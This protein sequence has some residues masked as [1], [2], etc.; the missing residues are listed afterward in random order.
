M[1]SLTSIIDRKH[2]CELSFVI[3]YT[4]HVRT[5]NTHFSGYGYLENE[6]RSTIFFKIQTNNTNNAQEK[7]KE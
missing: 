4:M 2:F 6:N 3:Y 5:L 7:K 1:F